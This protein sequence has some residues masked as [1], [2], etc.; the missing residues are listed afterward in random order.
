M[1]NLP[2]GW[3][4]ASVYLNRGA[5]KTLEGVRVFTGTCKSAVLSIPDFLLTCNNTISTISRIRINLLNFS[6]FIVTVTDGFTI[7]Q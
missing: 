5:A 7:H 3:K 1:K 4:K 2:L 6:P